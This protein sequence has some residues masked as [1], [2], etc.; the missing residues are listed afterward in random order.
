MKKRIHTVVMSNEQFETNRQC[1]RENLS[2]V[3]PDKDHVTVAIW[4]GLGESIK[5]WVELII[6]NIKHRSSSVI[7]RRGVCKRYI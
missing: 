3:K 7:M 5:A 4:M 2:F 6:F 1:L